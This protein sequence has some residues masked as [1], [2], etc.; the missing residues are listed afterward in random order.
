MTDASA[1]PLPGPRNG[2]AAGS[3]S[4]GARLSALGR[5]P[6]LRNVPHAM[7]AALAGGSPVR[8]ASVGDKLL[9]RGEPNRTL[10]LLLD[11]AVGV[12]L[13]GPREPAHVHLGV[14]EC[15]GELSVIDGL[16]AS[17]DVIATE[18][19]TLLAIDR[20]ALVAALDTSSELAHNLLGIL[21]ARVRQNTY[22]IA[23]GT[24]LQH[25][26]QQAAT[27]DGLTGLRNRRWMDETFARQLDRTLHVQSPASLMMLDVDGFKHLNDEHGHLVGDGI[28]RHLS[29]VLAEHLRPQDLLARYGGD[30]FAMLLPDTDIEEAARVAERLRQAVNDSH[31][32][33]GG[34]WLPTYT[35]SIGIAT[36]RLSNSMPGLIASADAA[37]YRAKEAGKN[38]VSR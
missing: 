33:P 10:F 22:T 37:L 38:R 28:L 26:L 15:F 25:Q 34:E 2:A 31:P 30:E 35:V 5:S 12:Y 7:V 36:A 18:P 23:E 24:R 8:Q 3:S 16:S 11:G 14:G 4:T 20:D 13:S 6:L 27:V 19:T 17:A 1:D 21:T 9:R 29:Q 32:A